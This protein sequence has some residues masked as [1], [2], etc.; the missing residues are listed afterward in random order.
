MQERGARAPRWEA[1]R[2]TLCFEVGYVR[3][4]SANEG[5]TLDQRDDGA[6]FVGLSL[7]TQLGNEFMKILH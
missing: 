1:S 5:G 3:G 4:V 6:V 7:G 2:M